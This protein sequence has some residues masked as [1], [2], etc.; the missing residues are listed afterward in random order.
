[1]KKLFIFGLC[2]FA[3]IG[4]ATAQN[5]AVAF[6]EPSAPI[7]LQAVPVTRQ[8]CDSAGVIRC[9]LVNWTPLGNSCYCYG[10]GWGWAC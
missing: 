10:Q 9:V 5:E 8:C 6:D 1:M 3:A 7:D 2:L 4:I